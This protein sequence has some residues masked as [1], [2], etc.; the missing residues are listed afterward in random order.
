MEVL[1][2]LLTGKKIFLSFLVPEELHLEIFMSMICQKAQIECYG[3][4]GAINSQDNVTN[5]TAKKA[6]LPA[7][8]FFSLLPLW[9]SF[10]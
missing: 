8:S 7:N 6:F 2:N 1:I 3:S 5:M 4:Q 9:P 10:S